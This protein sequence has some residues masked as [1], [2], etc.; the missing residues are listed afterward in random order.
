MTTATVSPPRWNSLDCLK[1]IACIAVV[2]I[3]YPI[4]G[5]DVPAWIG[6]YTKAAIL[7]LR[8]DIPGISGKNRKAA[9]QYTNFRHTYG[10]WTGHGSA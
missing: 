10:C 6:V 1:G 5:G 8:H 9:A 3:H 2:L 7:Y 4:S